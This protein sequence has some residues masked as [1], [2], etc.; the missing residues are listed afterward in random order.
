MNKAVTQREDPGEGRRSLEGGGEGGV[1]EPE[2]EGSR[3]S[4]KAPRK[5]Q[6]CRGSV[7][8]GLGPPD[9]VTLCYFAD[10][11]RKPQDADTIPSLARGSP[12]GGPPQVSDKQPWQARTEGATRDPDGGPSPP[13]PLSVAGDSYEGAG[14][15][16]SRP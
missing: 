9:C 7:T 14:S 8:Q 16:S 13:G 5:R 4:S 1:Y 10:L 3:P 12:H 15:T 11:S 6:P 2:E